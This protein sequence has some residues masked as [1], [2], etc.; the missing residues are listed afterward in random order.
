MF[1]IGMFESELG[2]LISDDPLVQEITTIKKTQ[3]RFKHP[4]H[5]ATSKD[6]SSHAKWN[7]KLLIVANTA[8]L[9]CFVKQDTLQTAFAQAATLLQHP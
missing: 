5:W 2:F 6:F 8:G 9:Q 7:V 4:K 1:A 3:F